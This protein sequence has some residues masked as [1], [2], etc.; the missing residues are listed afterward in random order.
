MVTY[1]LYMNFTID[2]IEWWH[3]SSIEKTFAAIAGTAG[4]TIMLVCIR[5]YFFDLSGIDVFFKRKT[6]DQ[7]QVNGLNKFVRHPLYAGTLLFAWSFFFWQPVLSN[8]ISVFVI[9]VYT[10]IGTYFEERKLLRTFGEDYK[11][12]A[13]RVPMLIPRFM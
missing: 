11:N 1:A 5:K 9:T 10:V 4:L 3:P 13:A 8:F 7:L 12:Y 6:T 2:I